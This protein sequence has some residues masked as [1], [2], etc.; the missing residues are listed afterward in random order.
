MGLGT[1]CKVEMGTESRYNS[2]TRSRWK[3]LVFSYFRKDQIFPLSDV[4]FSQIKIE[5]S[6]H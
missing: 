2:A 3:K 6:W 5:L 1:A 4:C